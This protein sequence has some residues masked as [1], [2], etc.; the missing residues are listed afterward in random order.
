[1][2]SQPS[3]YE[4]LRRPENLQV[5]LDVASYVEEL[6]AHLHKTFWQDIKKAL[7]DRLANSPYS[8]RWEISMSDIPCEKPY[9]NLL[10]ALKSVSA[11]PQ[12]SYLCVTL[13]QGEPRYKY[14]LYYGLRW[15]PAERAEPRRESYKKLLAKSKKL[16]ADYRMR[17]WWPASC[18]LE[19]YLR[20]DEVV[21]EYGTDPTGFVHNLAD[22]I[23]DY[24]TGLEAELY[25]FDKEI[26]G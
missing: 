19:T 9:K 21:K 1:M 10:I 14:Q 11:S 4:F 22:Q 12:S 26:L 8:K 24:F 17:P 7:F 3:I 2:E 15:E 13:E 6:R 25:A 5:A 16:G 23:W 18:L 20:S